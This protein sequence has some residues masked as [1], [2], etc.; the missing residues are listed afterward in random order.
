MQ[1]NF[2]QVGRVPKFTGFKHV[3][4]S[5]KNHSGNS[6]DGTFFAPAF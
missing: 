3:I 5:G 1:V 6:D 2:E 4:D